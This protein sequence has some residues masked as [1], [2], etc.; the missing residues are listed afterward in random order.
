MKERS[1]PLQKFIWGWGGGGTGKGSEVGGRGGGTGKSLVQRFGGIDYKNVMIG[2]ST[3][4]AMNW[5]TK[6]FYL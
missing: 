2:A 3:L 4:P 1:W 5:P 6:R